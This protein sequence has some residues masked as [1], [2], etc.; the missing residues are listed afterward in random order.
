MTLDDTILVEATLGTISAGNGS[1]VTGKNVQVSSSAGV[2]TL[3]IDTN[4]TAG[5]EVQIN[6]AGTYQSTH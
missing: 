6:L 1:A 3:W 4:N 2:T 5:A